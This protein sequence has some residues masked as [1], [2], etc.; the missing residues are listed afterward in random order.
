MYPNA[1][2]GP[3][4]LAQHLGGD[5]SG[6]EAQEVAWHTACCLMMMFLCIASHVVSLFGARLFLFLAWGGVAAIQPIQCRALLRVP[7]PSPRR[8]PCRRRPSHP[9]A[10][11]PARPPLNSSQ[12]AL[13]SGTEWSGVGHVCL[14]TYLSTSLAAGESKMSQFQ[15]AASLYRFCTESSGWNRKPLGEDPPPRPSV[16]GLAR[17]L[18][19]D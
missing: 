7:P 13:V 6:D 9:A 3:I 17:P 15:F 11:L 14:C 1:R 12:A 16:C 19:L 10:L 4:A 18:F 5:N 8:H 2:G